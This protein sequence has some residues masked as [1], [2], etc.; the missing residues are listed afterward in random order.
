LKTYASRV[1]VSIS[2]TVAVGNVLEDVAGAGLGVGDRAQGVGDAREE[3]EGTGVTL[4][5]TE[6]LEGGEGDSVA[7]A[8][9][10]LVT[11][12]VL[13]AVVVARLVVVAVLVLGIVRCATIKGW[14]G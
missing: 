10:V 1:A 6:I 9:Q 5:Q 3:V 13:V 12:L 14:V 8:S 2:V 4:L 7:A 11:S